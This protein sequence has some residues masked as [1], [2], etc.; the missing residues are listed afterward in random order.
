M[1]TPPEPPAPP[2]NR[3]AAPDRVLWQGTRNAFDLLRSLPGLILGTTMVMS[4]STLLV[5][6]GVI[7]FTMVPVGPWLVG[8]YT[9][10]RIS[11]EPGQLMLYGKP[12]TRCIPWTEIVHADLRVKGQGNLGEAILT[13]QTR[14]GTTETHKMRYIETEMFRHLG[15]DLA[16]RLH[17]HGVPFEVHG[18]EAVRIEV[19]RL[20]LDALPPPQPSPAPIPPLPP[21]PPPHPTPQADKP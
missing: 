3:V 4:D 19:T 17:P 12:G 11:I 9:Q 21:V 8:F 18:S 7:C 5:T 6:T 1:T 10:R 14:L 2:V 15:R 13:V 20:A 16:A